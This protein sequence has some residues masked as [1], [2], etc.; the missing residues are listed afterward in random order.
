MA[1]AISPYRIAIPYVSYEDLLSSLSDTL[2]VAIPNAPPKPRQI[3]FGFVGQGAQYASMAKH[4]YK[5]Q[6]LVKQTID[7]CCDYLASDLQL[8]LRT[9]LFPEDNQCPLEEAHQKLKETEYAQPALFI[10][11]YAI[12]KLLMSLGIHPTAMI[13]HSV[14]EYVAATLAGVFSLENA[15]KIISIRAK[16]MG[17]TT[18]AGAMLAVPLSKEDYYRY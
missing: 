9:L 17:K 10:V 12:S 7:D 3:I 8:D 15:L 2:P 18:S 1:A 4:L 16:L 6:P 13:G 11:E 14:G 5:E